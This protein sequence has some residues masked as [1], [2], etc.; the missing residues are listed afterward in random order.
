VTLAQRAL[1]AFGP[2]LEASKEVAEEETT[3]RSE[4]LRT[5][6]KDTLDIDVE[7]HGEDFATVEHF[8][9]SY[10]L[11]AYKPELFAWWRCDRCGQR[12]PDWRHITSLASLGAV[13]AE[14]RNHPPQ[15]RPDAR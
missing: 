5:L 8:G 3:A 6:I 15:C 2:A 12:S 10:R 7:L 1:E 9:F 14:Y 13:E 4:I 11:V